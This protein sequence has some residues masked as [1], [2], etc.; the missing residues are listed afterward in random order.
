[1]FCVLQFLIHFLYKK[2]NKGLS[3]AHTA[4]L[5]KKKLSLNIDIFIQIQTEAFQILAK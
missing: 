3:Y 5:L 1:M 4:V 2:E